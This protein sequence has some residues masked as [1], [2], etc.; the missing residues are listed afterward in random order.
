MALDMIMSMCLLAP[1]VVCLLLPWCIALTANN[2]KEIAV[3]N[4]PTAV[5]AATAD[6]AM[7]LM[8]GSLR[9]IHMPYT[10]V[11]RGEW[12]GKNFQL[13][14]DPRQKTLGIL[15][16]GGIGREVAH[17][18]RA[19]GMKIQYHNRSPL[20]EKLANGAEY[21]NFETL[22]RTSDILSL[23][24]SL[25]AQTRHIIGAAELDT[26]KDDVIIVNT[27]RGALIDEPA[28]VEALEKGKVR[29]ITLCGYT[30]RD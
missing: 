1:S 4:T 22:M 6:M 15:G 5:N 7:F 18:A 9:R 21:V 13:G 14:H 27:A 2:A 24:L 25:N 10:A 26:M 12:R 30:L 28:L 16:M 19:F 3:S 17:R 11:R 8:L 29:D 23:N 20:S